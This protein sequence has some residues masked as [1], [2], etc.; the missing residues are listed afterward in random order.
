MVGAWLS[1]TVTVWVAVAVLPAASVAVHVTVVVPNW[2]IAGALFEIVA[3]TLSVAEAFPNATLD[4]VARLRSVGT[5]IFD[6]AVI[7]GGWLSTTVTVCVAVAVLPAASVAV[8]ITVVVP[9]GKTAGALF[10][11]VAPTLSVAEAVPR[12]TLDAVARLGSV[13][14]ETDAGAAI[15]GSWSSITVITCMEE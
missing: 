11:I 5:I 3:P 9:N 8:H 4:A 13:F 1:T 12:A 2:K 14:T 7:D 15:E 6:G 10:E